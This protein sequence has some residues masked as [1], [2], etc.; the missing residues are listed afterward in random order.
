MEIIQN[1]SDRLILRFDGNISLANAIRRSVN[2]IP[3]LAIDDVEIFK[4]DSALYDEFIAHRLG[5][6]PLETEGSMSGKTEIDLKLSKDGPGTVLSGDLKGNAGI[7]YPNMPITS[8][9]KDQE[10]EL[11]ATARLGKGIEHEKYTPGL[12]YYR[13]LLYVK[14]KNPAVAQ[15]VQN[16]NGAIKP[17]KYKEGWLCDLDEKTSDEI[18]KID[19]GSVSDSSELLIFIESF[20]QI[21][22]KDILVKAIHALEDNLDSFEKALK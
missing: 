2:E 21:A 19:N 13:N 20:G 3:V 16:A 1:S 5:L 10:L 12:C 14:S 15:L 8:L 9:E 22:A 7:V 17:E 11:I 4:N 18:E 6:I